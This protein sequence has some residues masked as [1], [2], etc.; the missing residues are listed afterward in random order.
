MDTVICPKCGMENPANAMNCRNCRINLRFALEHPDQ[1]ERAKH[2]ATPRAEAPTQQAASQA[3]LT[4][5][6]WIARILSLF[7][8]GIFILMFIGEGFDPATITPREWVSLLFFPFGVV[9]GMILAWWK[10]GLGGAITVASLLATSFVGDVS[11]SGGAHMVVCASPG[12]LFLFCWFLS[13][14]TETPNHKERETPPE[15]LA[16][17]ADKEK[18]GYL[19]PN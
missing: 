6:R 1:I 10:E 19:P 17:L 11:S 7:F 2:A 14:V 18:E 9:A 16:A 4:V 8:I 13:K 12:F 5:L 3:T 15:P